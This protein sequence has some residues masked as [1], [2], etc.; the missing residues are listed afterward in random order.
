MTAADYFAMGMK[1]CVIPSG[2]KGP[3]TAKWNTAEKAVAH[4]AQLP[5]DAP[6][7]IGLLHA[8][9]GTCAIDIDDLQQSRLWLSARGVDIDHLL[10]DP[11]QAVITR[12]DPNR[13]KLIFAMTK[14]L[15]SR[16]VPV[17]DK[18]ILEFRCA[19]AGGLSVQDVLPP[20]IHPSGA[21][22]EWRYGL[23]TPQPIPEPIL[24][25]WTAEIAKDD[26]PRIKLEGSYN[27]SPNEIVSAV[28]A[29]NPD[30]DRGDWIKAGMALRFELGDDGF[31]TWDEWSQRGLKYPG[32][33]EV[34][35]QWKSFKNDSANPVRI[36]T[37]FRIAYS[38]G[39]VRPEPNIEL[40]FKNTELEHPEDM[41]AKMFPTA[42]PM[43]TSMVP[44][45]LRNYAVEI[46]DSAG[47][48]VVV[49]ILAGM[50]A[51]SGAIDRQTVL[52]VN[53]NFQQRP[54]LRAM[55]L[56]DPADK[57]TPGSKPM[58]APLKAIEA[59][60][61]DQYQA[62][63][64]AWKA[65]EARYKV[66][67]AEFLKRAESPEP[68]NEALPEVKPLPSKPV[69]RRLIIMDVTSQKAAAMLQNRSRGLTLVLDEMGDWL[70]KTTDPR[71]GENVSFW[72]QSYEGGFYSLDRVKD[73]SDAGSTPVPN[74]AVSAYGNVQPTVLAKYMTQL[75]ADGG[76][77]RFIYGVLATSK[78]SYGDLDD[79]PAW[80]SFAGEYEGVIRRAF[81]MPPMVYQMSVGAREM[82]KLLNMEAVD[83]SNRLK[84]E[85]TG[86][87]IS[88]IVG[89]MQTYV[90]RIATVFHYFDEPN[91][92]E[93]STDTMA[94]AIRFVNEFVLE[95]AQFMRGQT[96]DSL[97][98]KWLVYRLI[99]ISG[100]VDVVSMS[101]LKGAFRKLDFVAEAGIDR[102]GPVQEAVLWQAL[103]RLTESMW[104]FPVPD[105][106]KKFKS[107][108]WQIN[109]ELKTRFAELREVRKA[110]SVK[111]KILNATRGDK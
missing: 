109:P 96:F 87:F 35:K 66:D 21:C 68:S 97:V 15:P 27:T 60:A 13:S 49:P 39:W 100:D 48:D 5:T 18:V 31:R 42:P 59:E 14:P 77:A 73:G 54:I 28:N 71:S 106:D 74:C 64:L 110:N 92:V 95:H 84:Q 94:L 62:E 24:N 26:V 76:H 58:F 72:T 1:L 30:V 46:G 61:D 38:H 65:H 16:R 101:E 34:A 19:S 70:K 107:P 111:M 17:D 44:E 98:E 41:L 93:I 52:Y 51:M 57:K 80:M 55:L 86:K 90:L 47:C 36:G 108:R 40:L 2:Q 3:V 79:V 45:K 82:F 22:Y 83:R 91:N 69:P 43:D 99:D 53:K 29:I 8:W 4:A 25:I 63:T 104:V 6:Y 102:N 75:M 7:N 12:G 105:P 50:I 20:S 81:A 67:M 56:G 11:T 32:T 89:K 33:V 23:Q 78:N 88:S 9:S 85:A 103:D 37:L 10:N